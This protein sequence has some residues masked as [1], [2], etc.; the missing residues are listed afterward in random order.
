MI[1]NGTT[2]TSESQ[3]ISLAEAA[4]LD[5]IGV[6]GLVA[7]YN[8]E[9]Y[10]QTEEEIIVYNTQK[11][12]KDRQLFGLYL[13]EEFT[14]KSV[15]DGIDAAQGLWSHQRLKS[16]DVNLFLLNPSYPNILFNVDVIHLITNGSIELA[17]LSLQCFV[18]D[19][20]LLSYHWLSSDRIDWVINEMANF[21][22]V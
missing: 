15:E 18:P 21:L 4:G 2:I 6:N 20:M 10:E 11:S 7:I 1:F 9:I 8:N 14:R 19:S 12:V 3:L 5:T 16:V 17:Y 13:F 22:G